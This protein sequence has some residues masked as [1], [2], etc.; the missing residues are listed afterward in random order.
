MAGSSAKDRVI[1]P[2]QTRVINPI[3]MLAHNLGFPPPGV[4]PERHT[5]WTMTTRASCS[6]ASAGTWRAAYVC[7]RPQRRTRTR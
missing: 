7:A 1:Y 6:G 5:P 3:V 4:G 2:F